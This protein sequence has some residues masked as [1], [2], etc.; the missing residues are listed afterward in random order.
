MWQTI[1]NA[2]KVADLRK[3]ILFTLLI[4]VIFRIGSVIPVPYVAWS[5]LREAAAQGST[6][7]FFNYYSILTGGGL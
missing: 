6:N 2:W 5:A 4:I 1:K 3:K 7:E